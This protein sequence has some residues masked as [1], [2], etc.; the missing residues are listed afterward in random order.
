MN[1]PLALF[2]KIFA[3]WRKMMNCIVLYL[4]MAMKTSGTTSLQG[5]AIVVA[6]P[7]SGMEWKLIHKDIIKTGKN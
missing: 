1:S 7:H 2:E 3:A 6:F 4:F 5:G